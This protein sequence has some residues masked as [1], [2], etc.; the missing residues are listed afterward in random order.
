MMATGH[1]SIFEMMTDL[2][3]PLVLTGLWVIFASVNNR[4]VEQRGTGSKI[5]PH[6]WQC[7]AQMYLVI[8]LLTLIHL[9]A[10]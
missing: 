1:E 10:K 7:L 2:A 8:A 9:H 5:E 3:I 6:P 4:I